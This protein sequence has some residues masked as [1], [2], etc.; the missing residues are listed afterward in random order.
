MTPR[1][2]PLSSEVHGASA[3]YQY[4]KGEDDGTTILDFDAYLSPREATKI[5]GVYGVYDSARSLQYVGYSRNL[6]LALKVC[7]AWPIGRGR[8]HSSSCQK[9]ADSSGGHGGQVLL[10]AGQ[11]VR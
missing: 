3:T 1:P 6:I 5:A 11:G 7:R 4:L 8:R 2:L 9:R 10:G